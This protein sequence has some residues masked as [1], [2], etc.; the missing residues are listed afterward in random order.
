MGKTKSEGPMKA[1]IKMRERTRERLRLLAQKGQ[2]YNEVITTLLDIFE[3]VAEV[4]GCPHSLQAVWKDL[5]G[6]EGG[7]Q[8]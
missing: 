2:T 3:K 8:G 1:T 4:R 5:M 6:E 7:E